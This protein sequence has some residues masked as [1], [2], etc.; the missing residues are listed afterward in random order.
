MTC[1]TFAENETTATTYD[2]QEPSF[3]RKKEKYTQAGVK[4]QTF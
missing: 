3:G 1:G 2:S 4:K